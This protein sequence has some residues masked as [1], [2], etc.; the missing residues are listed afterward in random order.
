M[1][2]RISTDQPYIRKN[3][4]DLIGQ[5]G[6]SKLCSPHRLL[7]T[8]RAQHTPRTNTRMISLTLA[9]SFS[10]NAVRAVARK[11]TTR[12]LRTFAISAGTHWLPGTQP[13]P[14]LDGTMAGDYG[15]PRKQCRYFAI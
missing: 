4:S 1:K 5:S 9:S 6:F 12:S 7:G 2:I 11:R 3:I 14:Y 15:A 13:P 8:I 10:T